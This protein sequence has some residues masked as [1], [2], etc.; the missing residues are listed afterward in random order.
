MDKQ[1]TLDQ[2]VAFIKEYYSK[3]GYINLELRLQ[4]D[5]SLRMSTGK[6]REKAI[7]ELY[8]EAMKGRIAV[9]PPAVFPVE[10]REVRPVSYRLI[11]RD[12]SARTQPLASDVKSTEK[13][14]PF[15]LFFD[16]AF[17]EATSKR[18]DVTYSDGQVFVEGARR[19]DIYVK[20]LGEEELA[21]WHRL[22]ADLGHDEPQFAKN[23]V[24]TAILGAPGISLGMPMHVDRGLNFYGSTFLFFHFSVGSFH[25]ASVY[26]TLIF[27][28]TS[29]GK[30]K[31]FRYF[32]TLA[33]EDSVSPIAE[34][35]W[36]SSEKIRSRMSKNAPNI[37]GFEENLWGAHVLG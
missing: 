29:K 26:A 3:S 4:N 25:K 28:E 7:K 19:Q 34:Q 31:M 12:Q 8:E 18:Y 21:P 24:K 30:D 13:V 16:R 23:V 2:K 35:T 32:K 9:D 6:T 15:V 11:S 36:K 14:A 20:E 22:V 37:K 17:L 33:S 27:P 10:R 1:L 5:I